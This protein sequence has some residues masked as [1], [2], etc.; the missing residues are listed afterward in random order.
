MATEKELQRQQDFLALLKPVRAPLERF[1]RALT[2]DR[3]E[4]ADLAAA[5][6]ASAF[7]QFD[8]IRDHQAFQSFCFSVASRIFKRQRR[9]AR[10]FGVFDRKSAE[11]RA[12]DADST[13]HKAELRQLYEALDRLP[14][15]QRETLLLFELLGM[16]L[17]EIRAIQGGSLSGVKSRLVRGR[18]SLARQ[19]R[20]YAPAD[21]PPSAPKAK[22]TDLKKLGG[23]DNLKEATVRV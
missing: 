3:E 1:A 18:K 11:A 22:S 19:L 23:Q 15:K 16:K 5:T 20:E 21:R 6:I 4:A 7:E 9:R 8:R 14:A 10:L 13:E 2:R 17:E 12:D